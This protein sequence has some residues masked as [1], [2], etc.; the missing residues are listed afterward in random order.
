MESRVGYRAI[1]DDG[2]KVN[3]IFVNKDEKT[4]RCWRHLDNTNLGEKS[5]K[6]WKF[7]CPPEF[8]WEKKK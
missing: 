4:I 5:E 2:T 8:L 7:K 6:D 3:C 1:L